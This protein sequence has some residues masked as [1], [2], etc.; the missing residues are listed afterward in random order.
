MAG[1]GAKLFTDGS[2]L[3]AAQVNTFLMDQSIMRFATTA[4]RD[5]AF[6]GAGEPILAEGMTCYIDADN[7]IYTYD[8]SAWVKMVSASTPPAMELIT[9]QSWSGATS[10][11]FVGVFTSAYTNYRIV[12]DQWQVTVGENHFL[13]LRDASGIIS[14]VDYLTNRIEQSGSTIAG[15]TPGGGFSTTFMPSY[16]VATS[17]DANAQVAGFIDVFQP[18]VSAWTKITGQISRIDSASGGWNVSIAGFFK[19]TTSITGFSFVRNSTAT[20]SGRASV[21]GYRS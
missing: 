10:V 14:S 16:I 15:V 7:S 17:F 19:Q 2:V 11:D 12:I 4:A 13:R 9:T 6:G 5:A 21:Y 3:N 1:A 18:Q 20:M 8:G